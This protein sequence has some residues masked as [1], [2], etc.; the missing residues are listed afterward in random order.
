MTITDVVWSWSLNFNILFLKLEKLLE[1]LILLTGMFD[2]TTTDG[3]YVFLKKVSN[4]YLR[5][6]ADVSDSVCTPK[7][8]KIIEK[9]LA[10]LVF[11]WF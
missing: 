2:S 4:I 5:N 7:S 8:G 1:L 10:R 9:I 3:N 11:S 6:V